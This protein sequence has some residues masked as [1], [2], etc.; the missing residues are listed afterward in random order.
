MKHFT[1]TFFTVLAI[2]YLADRYTSFDM[3]MVILVSG[4]SALI[5]I[6]TLAVIGGLLRKNL[7][8]FSIIILTLFILLSLIM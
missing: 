5:V 6:T 1:A 3:M 8:S 7:Y 4:A 2:L